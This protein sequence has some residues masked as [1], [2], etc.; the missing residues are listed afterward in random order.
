MKNNYL[1]NSILIIAASFGLSACGIM[2]SA[3]ISPT[4]ESSYR[5]AAVQTGRVVADLEIEQDPKSGTATDK[6]G[7]SLDVLKS[8]AIANVLSDGHGD[9][10]LEPSFTV[11]ENGN[12]VTVTVTGYVARYVNLQQ[13]HGVALKVSASHPGSAAPDQPESAEAPA[14]S[15]KGVGAPAQKQEDVDTSTQSQEDADVQPQKKKATEG[16][17]QKKKAAR[18]KKK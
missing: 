13:A 17:P 1:A 5:T 7:A 10:L 9:V 4:K 16:Q 11:E 3:N 14:Q 6:A 8:M 15:H 12:T 2:L 18:K